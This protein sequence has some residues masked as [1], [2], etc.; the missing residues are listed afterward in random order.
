MIV[1]V[2]G[3]APCFADDLLRFRE[4]GV[5]HETCAINAALC[6][7]D[8][9]EH[10][11]T[12]HADAFR[13]SVLALQAQGEEFS[14]IG[15][16]ISKG[17]TGYCNPRM[18][19]G[20]GGSVANAIMHFGGRGYKVVLCGCPLDSSGYYFGNG[21]KG[22]HGG[23]LWSWFLRGHAHRPPYSVRSMSGNTRELFGYP[24]MEW[25]LAE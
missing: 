7:L 19:Q 2:V 1:A 14:T 16:E 3:S 25:L 6:G 23:E 5:E 18:E 24:D 15:R 9:F 21:Q 4:F 8:R 17:F 20:W 13:G 22:E 12:A 11:L 10:F